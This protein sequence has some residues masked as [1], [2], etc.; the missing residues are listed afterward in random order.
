MRNPNDIRDI[1]H[2][3]AFLFELTPFL[4]G[5]TDICFELTPWNFGL[6]PWNFELTRWNFGLTP[7][8]SRLAD[9]R[10]PLTDLRYC[11]AAARIRIAG[12]RKDRSNRQLQLP[13]KYNVSR[14]LEARPVPQLDAA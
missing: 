10:E 8:L 11:Q 12:T 3:A 9:T 2:F 14:T 13:D 7:R 5:L 4:F 6:T 1:H